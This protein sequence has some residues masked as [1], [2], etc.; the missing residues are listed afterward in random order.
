MIPSIYLDKE[1]S[2]IGSIPPFAT[3]QVWQACKKLDSAGW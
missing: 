1:I 3:T 2:V